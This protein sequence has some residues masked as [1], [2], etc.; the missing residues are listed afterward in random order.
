MVAD[1]YVLGAGE[2]SGSSDLRGEGGGGE[3]AEADLCARFEDW[4]EWDAETPLWKHAVA[5]SCAGVMEHIGM[6]PLDTVK[7]HM[8]AL[9]PGARPA[10]GAVVRSLA[11]DSGGMGFMRGCSAIATG[12]I[13]AH[14]AL[15]TSYEASKRRLLVQGEHEPVRAALCGATATLCHDCILTPMDLVKQR[16]QLGC[17]SSVGDCLRVVLKREG[18]V[19]L[20]RSVPTTLLMNVP[21][22][23][24]LV[25]ANESIKLWLG[26]NERR[27][28]TSASGTLPWYFLSAGLS[29]AMA[30]S[31]TQPLDVV[32]TRLQTQDCL[33]E[34]LP[35]APGR[36][37]ELLAERRQPKYSGFLPA[38][39]TIV[40][41]EG[42][43]AL[44][45]GM[46]PRMLHAI[47]AAAMC[48]GTYEVV[49]ASLV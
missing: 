17:Y 29:G 35:S 32:K 10:L 19:G 2:A 42:G 13:P 30:S 33:L 22:G 34:H 38:L 11:Q 44:F 25:A 48:W 23:S 41:E 12:C 37:A 36:P 26:V 20:Y 16:M 39:A 5:G 24:V 6:Y 9:R 4:E 45:R 31:A 40:R 14:V 21:F 1:A 46:L 18:V 27:P 15:F 3:G 43:S 49:K 8:Q 28:G 47:P 7:T